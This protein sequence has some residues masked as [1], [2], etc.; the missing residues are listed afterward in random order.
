MSYSLYKCVCVCVYYIQNLLRVCLCVCVSKLLHGNAAPNSRSLPPFQCVEG[1]TA[2]SFAQWHRACLGAGVT[3]PPSGT[4]PC[5]D[6]GKHLFSSIRFCLRTKSQQTQSTCKNCRTKPVKHE[7]RPPRPPSPPP[8]T[9]S[10]PAAAQSHKNC[11]FHGY[12][13]LCVHPS[14]HLSI[15]QQNHLC[16]A[17]TLSL[18]WTSSLIHRAEIS[19]P[20]VRISHFSIACFDI[21]ELLNYLPVQNHWACQ[22]LC[23]CRKTDVVLWICF[24][25]ESLGG[26]IT[27]ALLVLHH[28]SVQLQ[29]MCRMDLLIG[30]SQAMWP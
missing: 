12:S 21:W 17:D 4:R 18:M 27:A 8:S 13:Y 20:H 26:A 6:W 19:K 2:S 7:G 3:F 28:S 9:Q 25:S 15:L 11:C 22:R 10:N 24:D 1:Q 16:V 23:S 30:H 5:P 29:G 14:V